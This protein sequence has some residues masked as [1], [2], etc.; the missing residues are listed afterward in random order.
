MS[1]KR[2]KTMEFNNQNYI[3]SGCMALDACSNA[4]AF[5]RAQMKPLKTIWLIDA[6]YQDVDYHVR[7]YFIPGT[8][9]ADAPEREIVFDN[10]YIKKSTL[11]TKSM[12]FEFWPEKE[13]KFSEHSRTK[14]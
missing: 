5:Y 14:D 9:E 8:P 1:N 13:E 7:T 10:V 4:I 6:W 11:I 3:S 2:G 12:A